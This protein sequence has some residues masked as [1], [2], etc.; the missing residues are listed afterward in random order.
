M[1]DRS[2]R[3]RGMTINERLFHL[4]L[5]DQWD[6]AVRAR[7]RNAM[8]RLMEQCEVETPQWTV[9]GVLGNPEKYGY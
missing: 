6:K 3:L 9:D 1:N 2:N 8:M 7:D 4:G 5:M